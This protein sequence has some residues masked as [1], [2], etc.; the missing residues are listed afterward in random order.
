MPADSRDDFSVCNGT[1]HMFVGFSDPYAL[2][3][4]EIEAGLCAKVPDTVID[5]VV[6]FDTPKFLTVGR[7]TN[8]GA[9]LVVSCAGFCVATRLSVRYDGGQKK[10]VLV[11]AVTFLL[12]RIDEPGQ[13]CMRAHFDLHGEFR[14]GFTDDAFEARFQQFRADLSR[15]PS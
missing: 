6:A 4:S 15:T 1:E 13:Q 7:K 9:H 14:R 10:E 2:V 8:D 3:R 11:A 12:G 5:S